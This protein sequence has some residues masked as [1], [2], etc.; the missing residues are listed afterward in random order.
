M[1]YLLEILGRGLIA[2]L[3]GAFDGLFCGRDADA[4]PTEES[5]ESLERIVAQ[6]GDD[7]G[8]AV[9]L[10]VRKL[11][12]DDATGAQRLFRA[13]LAHDERNL[14]ARVGLAC[15]FDSLNQFD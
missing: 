11:R 8:A 15:T 2:Q 14:A 7:F 4:P 10:G 12:D 1:S 13:V 3:V 9:R 5:T 6:D